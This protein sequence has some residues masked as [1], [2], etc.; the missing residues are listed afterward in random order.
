M[1]SPQTDSS[2]LALGRASLGL[3]P[4][5]GPFTDSVMM[6]KYYTTRL[7]RG[8]GVRKMESFKIRPRPWRA[9]QILQDASRGAKDIKL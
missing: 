4:M 3:D 8:C 9:R 2:R 7:A 1:V 6:A 5:R